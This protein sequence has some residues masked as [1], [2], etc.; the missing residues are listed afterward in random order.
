MIVD[1]CSLCVGVQNY[2]GAYRNTLEGICKWKSQK[3]CDAMQVY[4]RTNMRWMKD[5]IAQKSATC[6]VW[7][8]VSTILYPY[9]KYF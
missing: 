4:I 1:S 8:N 9:A 3:F 6:P 2:N 5:M 7:H